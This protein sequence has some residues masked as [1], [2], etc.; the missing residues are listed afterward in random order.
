MP[1]DDYNE[2]FDSA[3]LT[4]NTEEMKKWFPR[5]YP[6]EGAREDQIR[7]RDQQQPN[8]SYLPLDRI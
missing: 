8:I 1:G 3:H 7:L 6:R 4:Y 2:R 5:K